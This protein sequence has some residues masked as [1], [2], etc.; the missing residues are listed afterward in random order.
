MNNKLQILQHARGL[1]RYG[2]GVPYRNYFS[3][4]PASSDFADCRA[5]VEQG[6]MLDHGQ[7][8]TLSGAHLFSVT[9]EGDDYIVQHSP[10]WHWGG[11]DRSIR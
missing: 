4:T 8:R 10:K 11:S 3:T 1:D 6:L 5:L 2:Q 7:C 9:Q